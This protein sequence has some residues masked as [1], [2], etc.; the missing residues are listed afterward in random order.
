MLTVDFADMLQRA[1]DAGGDSERTEPVV[2]EPP[3]QTDQERPY[4]PKAMPLLPGAQPPQ[5]PGIPA[6]PTSAMLA[7]RMA[8]TLDEASGN[9]RHR[10]HRAG[11]GCRFRQVPQGDERQ[12]QAGMALFVGRVGC[13]RYVDGKGDPQVGSR[14]D[15]GRERL[16]RL[17]VSAGVHGWRDA[18]GEAGRR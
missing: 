14:H 12:G 7:G 4:Y 17:L 5:M 18:R 10:P 8:F 3:T 13:G 11:H 15:G 16:L 2:F 6:R 1:S 9:V